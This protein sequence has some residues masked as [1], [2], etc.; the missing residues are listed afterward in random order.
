MIKFKKSKIKEEKDFYARMIKELKT[1][2]Y[3]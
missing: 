1:L 3:S 2:E